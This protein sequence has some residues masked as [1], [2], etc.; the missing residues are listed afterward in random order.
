M[1]TKKLLRGARCY[2]SGSQ[3]HHSIQSLLGETWRFVR[4]LGVGL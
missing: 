4:V 2:E 3:D 1:R